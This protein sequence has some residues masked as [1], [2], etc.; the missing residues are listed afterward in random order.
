MNYYVIKLI[1]IVDY[2]VVK[3]KPEHFT[4]DYC[5]LIQFNQSNLNKYF[6]LNINP[7]K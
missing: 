4:T 5:I 6:R 3:T 2:N 1:V 7:E